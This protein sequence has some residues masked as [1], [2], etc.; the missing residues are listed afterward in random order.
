ML[1]DLRFMLEYALA[2]V[3]VVVGARDF[4][5]RQRR[6]LPPVAFAIELESF[7]GGG[8]GPA[9]IINTISQMLFQVNST[10]S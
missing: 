5:N 1:F 2:V 4:S 6:E 3:V 9:Q 10:R 8:G 7:G